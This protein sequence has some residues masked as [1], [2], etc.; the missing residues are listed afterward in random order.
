[1]ERNDE[2]VYD[3]ALDF[4]KKKVI[5]K[6][7]SKEFETPLQHGI[8]VFK[9]F[10]DVLSS[11]SPEK[12]F[13][14]PQYEC[15]KECIP[16]FVYNFFEK[17]FNSDAAAVLTLFALQNIADELFYISARKLGKTFTI[18]R[19]AL[20]EALAAC[21]ELGA[22]YKIV[23]FSTGYELSKNFISET[24]K[25]FDE[26]PERIRKRYVFQDIAGEIKIHRA[27]GTGVVIMTAKCAVVKVRYY[28]LAGPCPV[29]AAHCEKILL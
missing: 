11:Y 23:V 16:V 21:G 4:L 17:A 2:E 12:R 13:T 10:V 20:A 28:G 1:M 29:V 8:R 6:I 7:T 3:D 9:T 18:T 25:A 26:L 15:I 14:A 5:S 24:A 22:E 19:V 27:D